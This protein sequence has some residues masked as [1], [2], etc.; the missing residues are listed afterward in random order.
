MQ[1]ITSRRRF[2]IACGIGLPTAV[3]AANNIP[4]Q[5]FGELL[6]I[7]V[8]PRIPAPTGNFVGCLAIRPARSVPNMIWQV[9]ENHEKIGLHTR[10]LDDRLQIIFRKHTLTW[11]TLEVVDSVPAAGN[12]WHML[13]FRHNENIGMQLFVDG[14]LRESLAVPGSKSHLRFPNE[15][16]I[17]S[18]HSPE[19]VRALSFYKDEPTI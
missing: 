6:D 9:G 2:L 18:D 3:F 1:L 10:R 19:S 5:V 15:P 7:N 16:L 8:L 13:G 11:G 4:S 12:R 14:T 17:E